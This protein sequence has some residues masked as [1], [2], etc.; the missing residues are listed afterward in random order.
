MFSIKP[1]RGRGGEVHCMISRGVGWVFLFCFFPV[2][3]F[4]QQSGNRSI[5]LDVAVTDKAGKPVPGLQ[6]TDFTL[7]DNKHPRKILSFRAIDVSKM[8]PVPP[9]RA[10]DEPAYRQRLIEESKTGPPVEVV[11]LVDEV[12]TPFIGVARVRDEI[13]KF[14]GQHSGGLPRPASVVLLSDSGTTVRSTPVQDGND[15]IAYLHRADSGLRTIRKKEQQMYAATD[16]QSLSVQALAQLA[17]YETPRPGRKLV[18]WISPGW[19]LFL[20]SGANMTTEDLQDVFGSVVALSDALRRARI[21]LYQVDPIGAAKGEMQMPDFQQ[22]FKGVGKFDQAH[23]GD[24]GLQAL[25]YR[26]GGRILNAGN[27]IAGEIATCVADGIVFYEIAFDGQPGDGPNEY[28]E[29]EL[30][31]D[32]PNLTVRAPSGYYAQP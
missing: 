27:D 31:I 20:G 17:A 25:A 11:L 4:A 24:L 19:P 3:G 21:T 12:N 7:L 32:K 28:H 14:L 9:V 16:R 10:I 15:L 29:L 6:P 2:S 13:E 1:R 23:L 5:T 30:K 22:F 18:V 26:S 8:A